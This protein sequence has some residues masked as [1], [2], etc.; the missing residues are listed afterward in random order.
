VQ[1][2]EARLNLPAMRR[3]LENSPRRKHSLSRTTKS[4]IPTAGLKIA[5]SLRK[6]LSLLVLFLRM[7]KWFFDERKGAK[8]DEM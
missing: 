7:G 1:G 4:R 5:S 8:M 6:L 2:L 3:S